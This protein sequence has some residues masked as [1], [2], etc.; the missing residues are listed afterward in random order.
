MTRIDNNKHIDPVLRMCKQ[1]MRIVPTESTALIKSID[2]T[3]QSSPFYDS[4]GFLSVNEIRNLW[5]VLARNYGLR[6]KEGPLHQRGCCL[7]APQFLAL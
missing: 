3:D 1:L 4:T 5:C 2:F 6:F 7:L